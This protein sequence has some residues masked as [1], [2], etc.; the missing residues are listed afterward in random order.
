M[1]LSTAPRRCRGPQARTTM[2]SALGIGLTVNC[3]IQWRVR[4]HR[5]Y[6][7]D[8]IRGVS[9]LSRVIGIL[10]L[11]TALS[12]ADAAIPPSAAAY[13]AHLVKTWIP[14]KDGVRLAVAL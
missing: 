1:E 3:G 8:F 5:V 12:V 11:T 9:M 7:C 6:C 10:M 4:S 14:M 2:D 13:A